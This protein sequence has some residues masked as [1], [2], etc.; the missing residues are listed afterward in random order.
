M[1]QKVFELIFK[2]KIIQC[3]TENYELHADKIIQFQIKVCQ[4]HA[5]GQKT[6]N[7]ELGKYAKV[8]FSMESGE[9]IKNYTPIANFI[10]SSPILVRNLSVIIESNV[11]CPL[12]K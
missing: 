7:D 2:V 6:W 8:Y 9:N 5:Q 1:I 11:F 10:G 4:G 3:I 12:E